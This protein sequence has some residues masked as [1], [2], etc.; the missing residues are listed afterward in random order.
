MKYVIAR[1]H[2]RGGYVYWIGGLDVSYN[3]TRSL[4]VAEHYDTLLDAQ[5]K[6]MWLSARYSEYMGHIEVQ[7]L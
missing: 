3:W 6:A 1:M 7:S 5:A 4:D 2:G